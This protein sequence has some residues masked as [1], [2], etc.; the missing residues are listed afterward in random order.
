MSCEDCKR[1]V[2]QYDSVRVQN[3]FR[4]NKDGKFASQVFW[5]PKKI[6]NMKTLCVECAEFWCR[7]GKDYNS[8]CK[9]RKEHLTR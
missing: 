1:N 3:K 5:Q 2:T 4:Y 7:A 9:P 8:Q 6:K